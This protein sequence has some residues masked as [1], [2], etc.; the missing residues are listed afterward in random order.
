MVERRI[1]SEGKDT[2][3]VLVEAVEGKSTRWLI[4]ANMILCAWLI[5]LLLES[6]VVP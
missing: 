6:E 4:R 1:L 3:H 5:S 2:G